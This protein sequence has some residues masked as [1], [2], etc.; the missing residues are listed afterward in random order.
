MRTEMDHLVLGN[1][2]FD[3]AAQPA[4]EENAD[5]RNEYELD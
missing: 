4:Y 2:L 1:R 5:W 3:K